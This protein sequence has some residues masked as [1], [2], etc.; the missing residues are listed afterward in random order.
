MLEQTYAIADPDY[1]AP[2]DS[3]V[4][5]GQEYSP[6]KVP[7]GWQSTVHSMWR[8]WAR[9]GQPTIEQGWKVH[10]AVRA[11][12]VPEVLDVFAGEC[13]ARDIP[14]KHVSTALCLMLLQ[15]KH[16]SRVQSGKL[17][18]AYPSDE[19]AAR[20]LMS[21][22]AAQLEDEEG[23]YILTDRRFGDS[24][25]VHYRYGSFTPRRRLLADGTAM[26]LLRGADGELAPDRR[27][28]RFEL[29][30]GIADPFFVEEAEGSAQS[31]FHGFAFSSAIRH[32]NAGGTYIGRHVETG[33]KVFIKE[34]RDHTGLSWDRRTAVDR[35]RNEWD[36]LRALHAVLPGICPEPIAYFREWEHEFM[37]TE[38]VAGTALNTWTVANS[39]LIRVDAPQQDVDRYLTRCETILSSI[40]DQ[41]HAL[42]AQGYIFG[43]VSPGNVLVAD[44]DQPRLVDFEASRGTRDTSVS[45]ATDGYTPP[46]HLVDG[47]ATIYDH[48]GV[49]ALAQLTLGPIH[50]V[51][52][53]YPHSLAH[54]K[55]DLEERTAVP[56]K[57][58]Q[59][60]V[61]YHKPAGAALLPSPAEVAADPE[62]HVRELR[63]RVANALLA[64][65]DPGHPQRMFPTIP[66]GYGTNT[67]C[68]AYGAAGVLHAL[69]Q[70]DISVDS[71]FV[72][73]FRR[74][75]LDSAETLAP[76][77][78]VGL[79]GI[80]WVLA[81]Y[82]LMDEAQDLLAKA[83][84]HPLARECASF[85]GGAAGIAMTQLAMFEHTGD[86]AHVTA[87]QRLM[88]A[89]PRGADLA[90]VL[91]KDDPTGW[92]HGRCGIAWALLPLG[93]VTGDRSALERGIRL[94]HDEL[95]RSSTSPDGAP[96]FHVSATDRR[97]MPYL[98]CGTAGVLR[99]V[100]R[101]NQ[102]CRDDRLLAVESSLM[103]R[104]RTTYTV[105][106]GLYQGLSGLGFA[107]ADHSDVSG[108]TAGRDA[109]LRT[110]RALFKYAVPG[111]TGV[112]FHG[113]KLKRL[114]AD[115]WSGSAGVLLFLDDVVRP[116]R[117]RL[118]SLDGLVTKSSPRNL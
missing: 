48:Y 11:E 21:T 70:C 4:E 117:D 72:E 90:T 8:T 24:K 97:S 115:L 35:L 92:L 30:Q 111:E 105:M 79:A 47:D 82:G 118:F 75:A 23:Q 66:D 93:A 73:R 59:R 20:S 26:P 34:A 114:S 96:H 64:M 27:N 13:F 87:A 63:D 10:V 60:V 38:F 6:S 88:D 67:L 80:A 49:A 83:A 62:H 76:G 14:F 58:W 18:V 46:A 61:R 116:R 106:S 55:A 57:L 107:L 102:V 43:D 29:P 51:A 37:V 50:D 69:R 109:A 1:Y 5:Q 28:P 68:V 12:R 40:E 74:E 98:F 94:L 31:G 85:A 54:L 99:A 86:E 36:T 103:P 25:V 65:G 7:D 77:L 78:H 91:G 101:Y 71:E 9:Q 45:V 113:E 81:E 17:L 3:S 19:Q 112:R 56:P 44:G 16:A 15:H 89:I 52:V 53:R 42:H 2:I 39:A 110:A 41:L 33:R 100:V 22:L 108:D 84:R 95:D 104:L 32:S